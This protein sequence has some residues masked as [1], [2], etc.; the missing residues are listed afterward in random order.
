MYLGEMNCTEY[1]LKDSI[2]HTSSVKDLIYPRYK[3]LLNETS[4]D[5]T[6]CTL[7]ENNKD[8]IF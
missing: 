4:F 1:F 2:N 3:G 5:N 7:V 6:K 8:N